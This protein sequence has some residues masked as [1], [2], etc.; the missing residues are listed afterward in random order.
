LKFVKAFRNATNI[1]KKT[2]KFLV[3]L[4]N[5]LIP[6]VPKCGHQRRS[7]ELV[8]RKANLQTTLL[9]KILKTRKTNAYNMKSAFEN[10]FIASKSNITSF[11]KHPI[12][13]YNI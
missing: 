2:L 12:R 11:W 4:L 13:C 8:W 5:N 10:K 1:Q 3:V 9:Q 7:E 6:G